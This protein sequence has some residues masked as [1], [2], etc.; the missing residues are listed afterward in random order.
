MN[1]RGRDLRPGTVEQLQA[2]RIARLVIPRE[3]HFI[4]L[5]AAARNSLREKAKHRL[6]QVVAEAWTEATIRAPYAYFGVLQIRMAHDHPPRATSP[7]DA[8]RLFLRGDHGRV[9]DL[10][11]ELLL[12][13][14]LHFHR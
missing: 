2:E 3:Q 5:I 7:Y 1:R 13:E 14:L 4:A 6:H 10:E 9:V 11:P 12:H 8:S